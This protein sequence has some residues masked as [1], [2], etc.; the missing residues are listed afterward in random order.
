MKKIILIL[1]I[2]VMTMGTAFA[3]NAV[4]QKLTSSQSRDYKVVNKVSAEIFKNLNETIDVSKFPPVYK[5]FR[6]MPS[7][8]T[9]FAKYY[10]VKYS[11]AELM[12]DKET[13]ALKYV[14][15][16]TKSA[17]RS[18]I[19]YNYPSGKLRQVDVWV[20]LGE[21]YS[22]NSDGAYIDYDKYV[23]EIEK[24]VK[25]NWKFPTTQKMKLGAKGQTRSGV[26]VVLTINYAGTL[27]Q[28]KA[29]K[30]TKSDVYNNSIYDAIWKSS[31]FKAPYT[32]T[33]RT[34][35]VKLDF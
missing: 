7:E 31:P 4:P 24:E 16:R 21:I 12:Y 2:L 5:N 29:F 15:F 34:I 20:Y 11:D 25:A 6:V 14:S 22:F 23:K 33:T 18:W 32:F 30:Q 19:M 17:P 10:Y 9:Q 8:K 27:E 3:E 1:S 13:K 28:C 26:E 35:D